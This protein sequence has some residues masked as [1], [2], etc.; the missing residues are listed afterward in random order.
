M[1]DP[2]FSRSR[3]SKVLRCP[4]CSADV[5]AVTLRKARQHLI[6]H[7]GDEA[8]FPY[9][10]PCNGCDEASLNS[11]NI[12]RHVKT[13]HKLNWTDELVRFRCFIACNAPLRV[14][15]L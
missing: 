7:L 12:I 1:S 8:L 9:H 6:N 10:C 5:K 13:T 4:V 14:G 3:D 11:A 15:G 2:R